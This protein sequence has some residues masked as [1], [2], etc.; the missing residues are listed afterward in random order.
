MVTYAFLHLSD[1][2]PRVPTACICLRRGC[3][4]SLGLGGGKELVTE[5]V[6]CRKD[7]PKGKDDNVRRSHGRRQ[8]RRRLGER[9]E[10]REG[11][12]EIRK[13]RRTERR[14]S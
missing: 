2:V 6:E 13:G 12:R 9:R 5:E 11:E 10:E 1:E 4:D 14:T 3:R 8:G 7:D